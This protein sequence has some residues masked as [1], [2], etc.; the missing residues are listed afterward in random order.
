M[1]TPMEVVL[2]ILAASLAP[3]YESHSRCLSDEGVHIL[4]T[5]YALRCS[6]AAGCWWLC[7]RA[8]AQYSVQR[9]KEYKRGW[10]GVGRGEIG[11]DTAVLY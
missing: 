8:V 9:I 6:T 7:S 3:C 2:S 10:V 4:G 5:A 11:C 1:N